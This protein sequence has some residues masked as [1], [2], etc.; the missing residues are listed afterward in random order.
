MNPDGVGN[1]TPLSYSNDAPGSSTGS[2]PTTPA[3]RTSCV[4]PAP[5][6]IRQWRGLRLNPGPPP[7]LLFFGLCP[8]KMDLSV[9]GRARRKPGRTANALLLVTCLLIAVTA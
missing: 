1:G 8:Q 3:P 9:G 2:S 4:C 5:S 7:R 6:V